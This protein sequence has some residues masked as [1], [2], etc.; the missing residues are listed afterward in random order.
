MG[1]PKLDRHTVC[2]PFPCGWNPHGRREGD[3][4]PFPV[5]PPPATLLRSLSC[6]GWLG[7]GVKSLGW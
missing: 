3:D 5:V 6:F 7:V 1:R 2:P 4:I